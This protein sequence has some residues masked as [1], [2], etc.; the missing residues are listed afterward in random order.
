MSRSSWLVAA[1]IAASLAPAAEAAC[2]IGR[3]ATLHVT[4][5]D[6][7]ILVP[8]TV[9]ET[10]VQFILA[11]D[12]E[13]MILPV[14]AH[15][16]GLL[17]SSM[18]RLEPIIYA[19]DLGQGPV[20]GTVTL[21]GLPI[22][23]QEMH[24]IGRRPDFGARTRTAVIG[25][26]FLMRYD[27]EFNLAEGL[28]MLY[29]N[30]GCEDHNLAYWTDRYNVLDM[31]P[32]LRIVRIRPKVNGREVVADINSANPYTALS[33]DTARQLDISLG[34]SLPPS[35]DF[36]ADYPIATRR[37]KAERIELD[38]EVIHS[39]TLRIR[40]LTVPPPMLAPAKGP[41]VDFDSET[42]Y[43]RPE[44]EFVPG[45]RYERRGADLSLGVDFIRAHRMM[46]AYSQNKVY[47]SYVAGQPF[48]G[49]IP[50]K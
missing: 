48:L 23:D 22:G 15:D 9:N 21:D 46:I 1:L 24:V 20:V 47:F 45:N 12:I 41:F 42:G 16:L 33:I 30:E 25:R 5:E 50:E 32:F 37:G 14:P 43:A 4:V 3:V 49:P 35:H 6:N 17:R 39:P 19:E 36:L 8:G 40:K 29:R 44:L 27:V 11:T 13:S 38:Q 31:D 2:K 26:D 18:A 28:V 10:P 34:S 7:R